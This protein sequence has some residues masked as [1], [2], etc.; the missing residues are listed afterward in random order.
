MNETHEIP[1]ANLSWVPS[2]DTYVPGEQ[3]FPDLELQTSITRGLEAASVLEEHFKGVSPISVLVVGLGYSSGV[4]TCPYETY[5]IAAFLESSQVDY[6]MTLVDKNHQAINEIKNRRQVV[7]PAS[8]YYTHQP[9]RNA[10]NIYLNRTKQS[11]RLIHALSPDIGIKSGMSEMERDEL[12]KIIDQGFLVAPVPNSFL[13]NLKA[14]KIHTLN[15]PI[16]LVDFS[17]FK[18]FNFVTCTNLLYLLSEAGQKLTLANISQVM[19]K[20]GKI[21]INC[22]NGA[23][24]PPGYDFRKYTGS[25]LFPEHGGWMT[26]DKLDDL[27]LR[28]ISQSPE[29][30]NLYITAVLQKK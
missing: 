25:P 29:D 27:G 17:R 19:E 28:I 30:K 26:R 23:Y 3:V 12:T 24:M 15:E 9:Y 4:L 13:A 8:D 5:Q 18:P 14:G 11:S 16:E 21:L 6:S 20:G 22:R 1:I 7:I 10:W 2:R